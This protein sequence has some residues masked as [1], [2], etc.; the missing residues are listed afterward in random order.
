[1][2]A[3]NLLIVIDLEPPVPQPFVAVTDIFPP[4]Y[5]AGYLKDTLLLPCPLTLIAPV[6][7]DH[8]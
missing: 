6:G 3:D 5:P 8:V 7:I 4:V 2:A 1:M